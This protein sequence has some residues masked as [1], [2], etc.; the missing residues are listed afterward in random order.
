M[1]QSGLQDVLYCGGNYTVLY[2]IHIIG[3]EKTIEFTGEPPAGTNY[4]ADN[5]AYYTHT[6]AVQCTCDH[7]PASH[8][9]HLQITIIE[10]IIPRN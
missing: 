9:I 3:L 2:N 8:H 1:D 6:I 4:R 10:K 5:S 7:Q